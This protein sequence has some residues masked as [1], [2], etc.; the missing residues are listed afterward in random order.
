MIAS[1]SSGST[2]VRKSS[3]ITLRTAFFS[4]P[5]TRTR[6][7]MSNFSTYC[8]LVMKLKISSSVLLFRLTGSPLTVKAMSPRRNRRATS[9]SISS[10]TK[11]YGAFMKRSL[12]AFIE[13]LI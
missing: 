6:S 7:S 5:E 13:V 1:S 9:Q 3:F 10:S 2:V 12:S 11:P 8:F 4:R